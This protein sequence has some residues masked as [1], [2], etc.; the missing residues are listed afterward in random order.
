[1]QTIYSLGQIYAAC[2]HQPTF[3]CESFKKNWF[4]V[5]E[6]RDYKR[7]AILKN[8]NGLTIACHIKLL[9]LFTTLASESMM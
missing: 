2:L 8:Q 7:K 3:F 5:N 9:E 4:S 1:M 6:C